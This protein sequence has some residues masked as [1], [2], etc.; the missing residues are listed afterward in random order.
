MRNLKILSA[1]AI[2]STA[3]AAPLMAQEATQEPGMIGFN[4][5]NTDYTNGGFGARTPS[6]GYRWYGQAYAGPRIYYRA[7]IAV[8][9]D[10]VWVR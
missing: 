2:L 3:T 7:P 9:D 4:Y 6:Y 1:A 10:D 5:P 8:Y